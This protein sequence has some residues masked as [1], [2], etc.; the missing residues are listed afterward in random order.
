VRLQQQLAGIR[1]YK[2]EVTVT[3]THNHLVTFVMNGY[4]ENVR[5]AQ[6][7]QAMNAGQALTLA[8]NYL[9]VRGGIGFEKTELVVHNYKGRTRLAVKTTVVP[10]EDPIGDWEVLVDAR[11]GEIFKVVDNSFHARGDRGNN[12]AATGTGNTFDPDPITRSGA[13][14]GTGGFTDNSDADSGDLT[15]QVVSVTLQDLTFTGSQYQLS[16]PFAAVADFESPFKG[17]FSQTTSTWNFTR[18]A[19]AFEAV[20]VYYHIDKSMRYIN[21]TLGVTLMP[22]QY[23]GGVQVD[24]HG[25]SG[26]DNS[27]YVGAAEKLFDLL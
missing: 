18:T 23:A 21:Q 10:A 8:K 1:V 3:I 17:T 20:L 2:A 19:D 24:P 16:G 26:Q 25:L 14:Y 15:A 22:F 5:L 12:T 11:T 13:T 27:H 6:A 7:M 9:G 4:R